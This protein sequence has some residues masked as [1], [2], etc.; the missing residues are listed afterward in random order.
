MMPNKHIYTVLYVW[1]AG[2]HGGPE[3]AVRDRLAEAPEPAREPFLA[4]AR[5]S[6]DLSRMI[7]AAGILQG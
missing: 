5:G 6:T 3:A 7:W 2:S 4:R 1:V